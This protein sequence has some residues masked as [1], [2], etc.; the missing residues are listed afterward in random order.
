MA[1]RDVI[2]NYLIQQG[3]DPLH[4][5]KA[6]ISFT[7][8]A[9]ANHVLNDLENHPHIFVL[10]YLMDRGMN[11]SSAWE[12]PTRIK[13]AFGWENHKF[14]NYEALTR[15]QVDNAFVTLQL[16]RYPSRMAGIFFSGI[17]TI[18]KEYQ[19]NAANLWNDTPRSATLVRRLLRFE[20]M[21]G[22]NARIMSNILFRYY[23][24]PLADTS[25]LDITP[26]SDIRRM[27][28]RFGFINRGASEEELIYCARELNP[29]YPGIF[30]HACWDLAERVCKRGTPKCKHCELNPFCPKYNT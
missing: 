1:N 4:K 17:R 18:I 16:H 6:E 10:A 2:V 29:S 21:G 13:N 9:E 25:H 14:E 3:R 8:S 23:K 22:K 19:G 7:E 28:Q 15:Q 11:S 20:G 12:I 5:P 27:F 26:D 30:D 24:I